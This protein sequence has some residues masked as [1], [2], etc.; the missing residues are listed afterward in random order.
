MRGGS[1]KLALPLGLKTLGKLLSHRV[2]SSKLFGRL[3]P[4]MS[5]KTR[6]QS[7]EVSKVFAG[8]ARDSASVSGIGV[9][10]AVGAVSSVGQTGVRIREFASSAW[11]SVGVSGVPVRANAVKREKRGKPA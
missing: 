9:G 4:A 5:L 3:S 10:E 8:D 7:Q 1:G 2:R 11:Q 6:F